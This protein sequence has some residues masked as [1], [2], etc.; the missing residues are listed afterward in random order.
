MTRRALSVAVAILVAPLL[1]QPGVASAEWVWPPS[2]EV[3]DA[4]EASLSRHYEGGKLRA[5]PGG[6]QR[7]A[8]GS[9]RVPAG[10]AAAVGPRGDS[11]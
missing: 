3:M 6:R 9:T 5:V 11:G 7:R 10:L 2:D 4:V 8:E 1:L